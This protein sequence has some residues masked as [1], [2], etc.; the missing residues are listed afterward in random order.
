MTDRRRVDRGVADD[1]LQAARHVD[2][3]LGRASVS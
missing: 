3:L 2:D 1:P